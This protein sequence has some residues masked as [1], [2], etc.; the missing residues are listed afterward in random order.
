MNQRAPSIRHQAA[1]NIAQHIR[2]YDLCRPYG[3]SVEQMTNPGGR[4]HYA[5]GFSIPEIL[6][7]AVEVYSP[8]WIRVAWLTQMGHLPHEG[9]HIFHTTQHVLNF[10][11]EAFVDLD[12]SAVRW[13]EGTE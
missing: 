5:V 12:S 11:R 3:G 10:L 6:D 4:K 2:D 13:L 9:S 7:G 1:L 8:R